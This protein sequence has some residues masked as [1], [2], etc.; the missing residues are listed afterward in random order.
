MKILNIRSFSEKLKIRPVNVSKLKDD[1]QMYF[2]PPTTKDELINIIYIMMT[3]YGDDCDLNTIDVSKIQ[4]FSELFSGH[5]KI[6][7]FNGDI[8]RWNV[9]NATNMYGMFVSSPF[10][11]DI[12]R[13]NVSKVKNMSCMFMF[14]NFNR[15]LSKWDVSKTLTMES[16]F[17]NSNFNQNISDW[18][19]SNV[20]NMENMF[21]R[22]DFDQDISGWNVSKVTNN[23]NMFYRCPLDRHPEKQPKFNF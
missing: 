16:M 19:V 11:G 18:N 23:R 6:W 14:A 3:Y 8:S 7:K 21:N 1:V 10:N 13:W 15:N 17:M 4:D 12:S 22:S 9:S 2:S 5:G 20:T